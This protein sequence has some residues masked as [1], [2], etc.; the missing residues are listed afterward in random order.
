M[1]QTWRRASK[2]RSVIWQQMV[3]ELI[4]K[5]WVKEARPGP[6]RLIVQYYTATCS[7][8]A[9][10]RQFMVTD[11]PT[12]LTRHFRIRKVWVQGNHV[13]IIS[14]QDEVPHFE[15]L[16]AISCGEMPLVVIHVTLLN[17]AASQAATAVRCITRS[18]DNNAHGF[19]IQ[20]SNHFLPTPR[21]LDALI[22]LIL[23]AFGTIDLRH[24]RDCGVAEH[25]FA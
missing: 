10:S 21:M 19:I 9:S 7:T 17:H 23:H 12:K 5:P 8:S 22:E 4:S 3:L 1:D 18:F 14:G 25:H 15:M 6:Y 20:L 2:P 24:F 13:S 11:W 16:V